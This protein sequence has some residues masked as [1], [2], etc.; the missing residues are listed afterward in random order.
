MSLQR[1]VVVSNRLPVVLEQT[2]DGAWQVTSGSGG[3]VTALGPVLRDRGGVW[4]GWLGTSDTLPSKPGELS[5]LL[6]KGTRDSG[7]GLRHV[8]L[9]SEEVTGYYAGFSNELLWPLFHEFT[10]SCNFDPGYWQTYKTVNARFADVT[11]RE[12]RETD[13]IWV[14]DYHLMLLA[15]RFKELGVHRATGFFLH[16]PFPP[17]DLFLKIP[18][19]L[20]ILEALL[21]FDLIGFQ[22]VRDMRNFKH[23]VQNIVPDV[24]EVGDGQ[25]RRYIRPGREVRVGAFPISIDFDAFADEAKRQQKSDNRTGPPGRRREDET[26]NI[27]GVD[28][29]DYTKGIP[30]R[31]RAVGMLLEQ[32]PELKKRIVFT[33]VVVPSR[34]EVGSYD[35]LK[36]EIEQLVGET[37]GRHSINGWS[38]IH[39][40]FRSLPRKELVRAYRAADVCLVTPLKDGMN[41]VAKE[42]CA[43]AVD[44]T[45]VL[46]LSEFAGAAAEMNPGAILVNPYDVNGVADAL[47]QGLTMP[48]VEQTARMQRMRTVL[49]QNTIADW[50]N[51]FLHA[52]ITRDLS[53]FPRVQ[54]FVPDSEP[55]GE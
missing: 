3:L 45:G 31:I 33:Q 20:Q 52:A 54:L 16:I 6:K 18:W 47:Y 41:L 2:T 30:E 28:R 49:R 13:Y 21:E 24:A 11:A 48:P 51:T 27:L 14:H 35:Q 40:I 34:Q 44:N 7:F 8:L 43:C 19:R 25:V 9:S 29:L 1:L 53:H 36:L 10:S 5:R 12:S 37:N 23:C 42:Y 22:T 46:I 17:L 38:P 50:A 39:Y 55:S 32:H 15:A 26:L 4:I